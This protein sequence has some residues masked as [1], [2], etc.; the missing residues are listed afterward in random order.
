MR[1][2]LPVSEIPPDVGRPSPTGLAQLRGH[3]T[4][5]LVED[6][7]QVRRVLVRMLQAAGYV[8]HEVASA[9]DAIALLTTSAVQFDL[10]LTDVVLP[11]M[12]GGALAEQASKMRPGI[13]VL[14][15]SGYSADTVL[16][17]RLLQRDV[18]LLQKPFTTESLVRKVREALDRP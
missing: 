13:R 16:Q 7:N 4:I 3:E 2:Y 15:T 8:V 6:E 11:R 10:L 14:F 12:G 5:L 1:V 9:E 18:V 17:R